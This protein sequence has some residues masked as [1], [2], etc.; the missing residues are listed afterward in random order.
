MLIFFFIFTLLMIPFAYLKAFT[1]SKTLIFKKKPIINF[2]VW[3]FV[4]FPIL[5]YLLVRDTYIVGVIIVKS[6]IKKQKKLEINKRKVR[7]KE[8]LNVYKNFIKSI[9]KL[10][11]VLKFET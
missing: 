1:F 7:E 8:S 5:L 2:F 11:E 6:V 4:G 10:F 3:I 9:V